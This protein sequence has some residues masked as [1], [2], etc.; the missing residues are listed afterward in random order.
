M[1]LYASASCVVGCTFDKCSTQT[2]VMPLPLP[3]LLIKPIH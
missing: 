3:K 2:H 1:N